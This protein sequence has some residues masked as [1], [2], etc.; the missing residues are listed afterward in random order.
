MLLQILYLLQVRTGQ[1]HT[2][3]TLSSFSCS[4]SRHSCRSLCPIIIITLANKLLA[5]TK[6]YN[7]PYPEST[8]YNPPFLYFV[9]N[10]LPSFRQAPTIYVCSLQYHLQCCQSTQFLS[11]IKISK[12][13]IYWHFVRWSAFIL[14]FHHDSVS[15]KKVIQHR[16]TVTCEQK[17]GR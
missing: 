11:N 8:A 14:R 2:M 6:S 3:C 16:M 4:H 9:R 10:F 1:W 15:T 5:D 7:V 13:N 12:S 17:T